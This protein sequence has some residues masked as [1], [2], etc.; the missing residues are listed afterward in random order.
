ML[1]D[2]IRI[3]EAYTD[4]AAAVRSGHVSAYASVARAHSGF[5]ERNP[6]WGLDLTVVPE[7]E[8]KPAFGSFAFAKSDD[9]FRSDIDRVLGGYLGTSAHRCMMFRYGFSGDEIDLLFS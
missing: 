3:F 2:R 1:K 9:D 4:T 7:A 6:D 5:I 8:K